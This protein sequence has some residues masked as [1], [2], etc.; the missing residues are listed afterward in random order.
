MTREEF[1]RRSFDELIDDL[2]WS[3]ND[4]LSY[5]SLKE[6]VKSRIDDDDIGLATPYSERNM[7][8]S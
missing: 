2:L 7:E 3:R 1:E 4:I 8:Q 6:F 5:E